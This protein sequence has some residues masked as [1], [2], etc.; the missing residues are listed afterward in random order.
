MK[1][2]AMPASVLWKLKRANLGKVAYN[3]VGVCDVRNTYVY[4]R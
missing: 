2:P 1:L 4:R 3:S